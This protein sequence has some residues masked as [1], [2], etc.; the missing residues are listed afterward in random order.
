[1]KHFLKLYKDYQG[2]NPEIDN[3]ASELKAVK[4]LTEDLKELYEDRLGE[5]KAE[6]EDQPSDNEMYDSGAEHKLLCEELI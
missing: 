6:L 5:L 3:Y 1:M 2:W 4:E